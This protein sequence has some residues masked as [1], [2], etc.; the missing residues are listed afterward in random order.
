MSYSEFDAW[1]S[2]LMSEY[3]SKDGF[4]ALETV[5]AGSSHGYHYTCPPADNPQYTEYSS[6]GKSCIYDNPS[7][8]SC[9]ESGTFAK[10]LY[11]KSGF[12]G[13]TVCFSGCVIEATIDVI[14]VCTGAGSAD[15][16]CGY[17][18]V[19][20]GASCIEGDGQPH[21]PGYEYPTNPNP[22][23]PTDPTAPLPPDNLPGTPDSTPE[24]TPTPKPNPNP[25]P[26]PVNPD[27]GDG[28][29][30][31]VQKI[32]VSNQ[33]LENIDVGID[34]LIQANNQN[35]KENINYQKFIL[36]ELQSGIGSGGGGS[37]GDDG[38]GD[39]VGLNFGEPEFTNPFEDILSA[40][41]I[42]DINQK[43]DDV[44]GLINQ[45]IN[46]FKSLVSTPN[47]GLSGE[48]K[49]VV[50]EANHYGQSIKMEQNFLARSSAEFSTIILLICG[51]IAFGVVARR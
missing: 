46:S 17:D 18:A 7:P 1:R 27:L 22:Q 47:Y 10:K 30:A 3:S 34:N 28:D 41:D 43:T 37:G 50:V 45:K 11:G 29:S 2:N 39:G 13:Y 31:I 32:D 26:D 6:D 19:Y 23:P 40:Q 51:I 48:V 15:E 5:S 12:Q 36:G 49:G 8:S 42:A 20:T 38:S 44:K 16:S 21:P 25:T 33:Y 14:Q 35:S 9:P 4:K 24:P